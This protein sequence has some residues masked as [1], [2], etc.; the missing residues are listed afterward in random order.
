MLI[1][2]TE[3]AREATERRLRAVGRRGRLAHW[4]GEHGDPDPDGP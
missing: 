4:L 1:V 2:T 3:A